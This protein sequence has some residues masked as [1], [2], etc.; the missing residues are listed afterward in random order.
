[1]RKILI[2]MILAITLLLPV[3]VMALSPTPPAAGGYSHAVQLEDKDSSTWA[4]IGLGSGKTAVLSYN[5]SGATFG[6]NLVASGLEASVAYSLIYYANPYPGNFPGKLIAGGTSTAEGLLTLTGNPNL[7]M[8][9]PTPPDASMLTD[10]S[11]APDYYTHAYGAK[12]WLVPTD[13]YDGTKIIAW[14]PARFLFETDV[15]TY[16]DTDLGGGVGVP[17]TTV[18]T[19][20]TATIGLT[21]SPVSLNF[22]SVSIGSCSTPDLAITLNNTGNVP[23]NVTAIPTAGFYTACLQLKPSIA[24]TYTSAS[25]WVSPVIAGSSSLV[26][27][28]KV[29]P[30]SAY[31]G[32]AVGRVDFL[33]SFA[34]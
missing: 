3:S 8:S 15:I 2:L 6:F 1:M 9:L 34:P 11:V 22:G 29:C 12:I 13:C 19:E 7:N 20:P 31:S 27:Y 23:I 28:A 18:I 30:T 21:I 5:N 25:G 32:T 16:T 10:H 33:A 17:A 4:I 26:I 14:S 24:G